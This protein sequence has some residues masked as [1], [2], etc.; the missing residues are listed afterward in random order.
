MCSPI[1]HNYMLSNGI[2]VHNSKDV[3]DAVVGCIYTAVKD[4]SGD[5][6]LID[7]LAVGLKANFDVDNEDVFSE[8]ELYSDYD[9]S[10]KLLDSE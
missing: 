6:A 3:M 9:F 7:D 8:S 2:I 10:Y 4:E 1:T 5:E